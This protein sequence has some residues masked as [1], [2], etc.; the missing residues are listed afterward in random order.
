MLRAVGAAARKAPRGAA[1]RS[2]IPLPPLSRAQ[3]NGHARTAETDD[4]EPGSA[5]SLGSG[6]PW[7]E[8]FAGPSAYPMTDT[9]ANARE[10]SW[11]VN[12]DRASADGALPRSVLFAEERAGAKPEHS[13]RRRGYDTSA[14]TRAESLQFRRIFEL[15]ENEVGSRD[16]EQSV[17][18]TTEA[19]DQ[20]VSRNALR[21]N[22]LK[23]RGGGVGTRFE[24]LREGI[25][26]QVQP[27]EMDLGMDRIWEELQAQPDAPAAW[28]WAQEHIW[29]THA[30]DA[31]DSAA[32]T[33]PAYGMDTPFYAPALH[34]LLLTLRDRLH[35]PHMA[36][37]VH[38]TTRNAGLHSYV[39]GCT[40]AL[41]AEV[42]RTQWLCLRDAYAVLAT[43]REARAAG[44]LSATRSAG[45]EDEPLRVQIERVRN[46]LRH[47]V[48]NEA[49]SVSH[50]DE[51]GLHFSAAQRDLLEVAEQLRAA[52]GRAASRPGRPSLPPDA[53]PERQPP[54]HRRG[55]RGRRSGPPRRAEPKFVLPGYPGLLR[56]P[57]PHGSGSS[58]QG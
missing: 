39:L 12:D 51:A 21:D 8:L 30:H 5:G 41:Y 20:F 2:P 42:V 48:I 26:A 54:P 13:S 49:R 34:L 55:R 25:A 57:L 6:N 37:A 23:G 7:D 3:H 19:L 1:T 38:E 15:L 17:P 56:V 45:R 11:L 16:G 36:L 14:L 58:N 32:E 9:G 10:P 29:G 52:A 43:V 50:G 40:A 28:R 4:A 22:K 35:A 44:I 33:R 24:V 53:Q 47:S 27:E 18:R 46:E 31:A